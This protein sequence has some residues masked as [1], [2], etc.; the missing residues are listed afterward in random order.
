LAQQLLGEPPANCLR[1][2]HRAL[3]KSF[4]TPAAIRAEDGSAKD[5]GIFLDQANSTDRQETPAA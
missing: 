4:E 5:Q 3:T 2:F 1:L